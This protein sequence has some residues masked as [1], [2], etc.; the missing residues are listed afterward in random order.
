MWGSFHN[1]EERA[2]QGHQEQLYKS[3]FALPNI[4]RCTKQFIYVSVDSIKKDI[5][6]TTNIHST[7][8]LIQISMGVVQ[9]SDFLQLVCTI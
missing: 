2:E 4:R 5:H 9:V 7:V 1:S 8:G 6:Q 3:V